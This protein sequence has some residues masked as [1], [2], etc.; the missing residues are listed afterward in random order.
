MPPSLP[1]SLVEVANGAGMRTSALITGMNEPLASAAGNAVE[2][3]N[4]VDFLTGRRRDR[5]LAEVTLALAAEMLVAAGIAGSNRDGAARAAVA[6][7]SGRAAETFG[8]MVAALGGPANFVENAERYL[9]VAPVELAVK[10][11]RHG[12]V[13]GI[14]TRD[15]GLAVV[16]LGG[17]RTTPED[18][19]DHAVGITRLLPV[20]SEVGKGEAMAFVHARSDAAAEAAAAT[21]RA[22][23]SIGHAK[24]PAQKAVIRRISGDA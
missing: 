5:R 3:E 12:Y 23:Y 1:P 2:V 24:P 4:A 21:I 6:L 22:A 7:E 15:I 14:A 18:Q 16:A 13:T 10:A 11:E 9:P 19:I 8:K 17:G 20:G